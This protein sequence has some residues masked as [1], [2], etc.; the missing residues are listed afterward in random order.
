MENS[1]KY[2]LLVNTTSTKGLGSLATTNIEYNLLNAFTVLIDGL[3]KSYS[4]ITMTELQFLT[5]SDFE[6][7]VRDFLIYCNVQDSALIQSLVNDAVYLEVEC[8][9]VP[10]LNPDFIIDV[11][12]SGIAIIDAG[13]PNGVLE[14]KAYP[15]TGIFGDYSW[16]TSSIFLG[17]IPAT[18]YYVFI[19][20]IV[21]DTVICEYNKLYLA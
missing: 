12:L 4:L 9:V 11:Y 21:G 16:Q 15:T 8:D 18:D 6:T 19:R 7:R 10:M 5:A 1:R 14:Y 20:D 13:T 17:L 2:K 3:S